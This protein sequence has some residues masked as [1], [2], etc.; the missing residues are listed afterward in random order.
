MWIG[1]MNGIS[2]YDGYSFKKYYN[3]KDANSISDS[4]A[5]TICEDDNG[6]IWIGTRNGLNMFNV[7][8]EKFI[9]YKNIPN[10][11]NS[12]LCNRLTT[13]KIDKT[14][15]LWIGTEQGLVT[16][17]PV[18]H[19][20]YT[21]NNYPFNT[22][23]CNII[24]SAGDFIWIATKEGVVH[25]NIATNKYSFY[26]IKVKPD[27]YG[28]FFWSI[29]ENNKDLYIGTASDGLIR[30]KYNAQA[31][32][33][34]AF[35][36]LNTFAT[37]DENLNNTAIFDISKSN[38]GTFW[39]ATNRGVAKI[40]K[41][42]APGASLIFYRNNPLSNQSLSNNT[43]YKIFID[44]TD[45]LWCGTELGLNKFDL[46]LLPFQ[47]FTFKDPQS[48]DQVRS[49][50]TI[51]GENIWLGTSKYGFYK[52]NI[53]NN[54][55]Q[56]YNLKSGQSPDNSHRSVLIDQNNIWMGT[57]GG[58]IKLNQNNPLA[59]QKE[60]DGNAVFAFLKDSK[61]NL[62]IGT[63]YGLYQIK[64]DGTKI[65]YSHHDNDPGSLSS[66]FVRS[67]Y[68]DHNGNIWV[69]FETSGLSY[70][71][72]QT[73]VFTR[74]NKN[75]YGEEVFGN[76]IFSILEYPNNVIWAGSESGLNKINFKEESGNK[77]SFII[78]NYNESDG[79]SDKSVN[80][81]LA[82]NKGFLWISTI[83]GLLDFDIK[84]EQFRNYVPTLNFSFSCSYKF[85]NNKLLFGTSDGFLIFDPSKVSRNDFL[86]TVVI[87]DLKLFNK[88]VEINSKFNDDIPLRESLAETKE[89]S[90]GYR[91]N[92]FT[93]GFAGL[94]FSNPENNLYAYKM[95]GFD[96]DW[97]YT[98]ASNRTATYTNLDPGT[99][100]FKV[101]ASNSFGKWNEK[102]VIL[103][104]H[105]FPP[106]WK[107]WWAYTIYLALFSTVIYAVARY[108]LIHSKQKHE[109][110]I[111]HKMRLKEEELHQ[112]QLSFFTNIT[113]ELQTPLT[114]IN[115]SI[116]RVFYKKEPQSK[117]AERPY[118]LSLI[119]QQSSRLT[120]LVNQ[121]LD[122]RKAEAGYLQNH[123][124]YLDI[125]G[126]LSNI[127]DLFIPLCEQKNLDYVI[128][129]KENIVGYTDKDKLEKII[130]NLLS[131]AF[132]HSIHDQKII[133]SVNQNS[134]NDLLE[135]IVTNSGCELT[136][137]QLNQI[138]QKFFVVNA[139]SN[140]KY[141]N[142][143]GLAF[144]K[145]LVTLL[146]GKISVNTQNDWIV[147]KTHLPILDKIADEN[148]A[149]E[150]KPQTLKPSYL[151]RSIA[152]P[153]DKVTQ[154]AARENNKY[155]L[156]A[157]L[158]QHDKKTILIVEDE[159]AIRYLLKDLLG[160]NYIIYEAEN[161]RDALDLL[162]TTQPDLIISDIMMPDINGLELCNKVK[163]SSDTCHI[164]FILLSARSSVDHKTE[165]YDAGADAY[166]PKPF[167]TMHLLVR[168]RK[169]LEYRER[170]HNMFK[171]DDFTFRIEQEELVSADKKF[172]NSLVK[173]IEDNL[174][175]TELD[176]STLEQ[177]LIMSK[178]QLYRKLKALSNMAPAEFIKYI[179]LKKATHLL[180]STNLTVSEIFYRTGFN[181]QSYFF[182]EFKK[183]YECSPNEFRGRNRIHA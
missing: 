167:D 135:I 145:Q 139:S 1:T 158:E 49:I 153:N 34:G 69:G 131:N 87:S 150:D 95:V 76:I 24:Q 27:P 73:G 82:D 144:T 117:Q 175:D 149:H 26:K 166:I 169:L 91:N 88:E 155:A 44:K 83:K 33:Y 138:F 152:V 52:Y 57:L 141:S 116:E 21:F 67:L 13:L 45:I 140:D 15:K 105:I 110:E 147:F 124:D 22:N 118:Y 130:F 53:K 7:K 93:L 43:V 10:N 65:R 36:Y 23:I 180:Q 38:S 107:T 177:K 70:L 171:R 68:E 35:E 102:P 112:E 66:E 113:H 106:P 132:K 19:N 92:V 11:Q 79:L 129:I 50:A 58:A 59:S 37:G 163:N 119:H 99:Y 5:H 64:N 54:V 56:A 176:A 3:T 48:E 168:V 17:S 9:S 62:W 134:T 178:M 40:E 162:K 181:N 86:P 182:R 126:L 179:R 108:I 41:L 109:L 2:K 55:T 96:K 47:Y 25:Y 165:G 61:G 28:D 160:E 154:L 78:K 104:I 46:H 128:D 63:N 103:T 173:I 174:E 161:G 29:F 115:G 14:G 100:Y 94:H 137:D 6:N 20:F 121:L 60:I 80:G 123:F 12:L 159:P 74:V 32:N 72:P 143:I 16:F 164:P 122:F 98:K 30:M 8:E 172:L 89:I 42:G 85:N 151:L 148:Q 81:I 71:N 31:D 18:T 120:Y 157:E 136:S 84:K 183:R 90:L 125:S 114:L 127:A 133:F 51:D 142:G 4:W 111:A 156:I 75:K 170:L 146:K 97:I 77:Y 101:K 39:L